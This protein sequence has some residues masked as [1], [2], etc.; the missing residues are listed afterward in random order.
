MTVGEVRIISIRPGDRPS[1]FFSYSTY[2]TWTLC[3]G[4]DEQNQLHTLPRDHYRSLYERTT[5]SFLGGER[6]AKA[7][8]KVACGGRRLERV[9][10]EIRVFI[11][12]ATSAM[13]NRK[14]F[15]LRFKS[16]RSCHETHSSD[17]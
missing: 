9:V 12:G 13:T 14:G 15:P 6:P 2:T 11:S 5:A 8:A 1:R 10:S 3:A 7:H 16:L 17:T 4:R